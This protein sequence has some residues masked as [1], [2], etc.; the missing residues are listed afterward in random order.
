MGTFHETMFNLSGAAVTT[1]TA[2]NAGISATAGN[3]SPK[4][5]GTL[6][7]ITINLVPQAASSLAEHGRFHLTN[8]K[9]TPNV[10]IFWVPGF[11]LQTVAGRGDDGNVRSHKFPCSLA[12]STDSPIIGEAIYP[13][14]GPVTPTAIIEG[15]FEGS[16]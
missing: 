15:D 8:S 14:T 1:L 16:P 9:W 11:G 2:M 4:V 6:K 13:G 5:N 7:L 3:Y 10:N 12:V